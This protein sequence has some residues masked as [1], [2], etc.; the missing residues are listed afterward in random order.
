MIA[1][2]FVV[3][4]GNF[5][6]SETKSNEAEVTFVCAHVTIAIQIL[7]WNNADFNV[8]F[9]GLGCLAQFTYQ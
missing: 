1:H 2:G 7:R 6:S 9:D 5:Y 4:G 8:C 3:V